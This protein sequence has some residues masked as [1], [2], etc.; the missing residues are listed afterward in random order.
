[1]TL[2]ADLS[3]LPRTARRFWVHE[4]LHARQPFAPD[5]AAEYRDFSGYEEGLVEG[6]ARSLLRDQLGIREIAGTFEHP[7]AAYRGLAL[8]LRVDLEQLWRRLWQT[9]PGAVRAAFPD[10]VADLYQSETG[11]QLLPPQVARCAE[12]PTRCFGRGRALLSPMG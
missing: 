11:A 8:V 2:R 10:I 1:M 12:L 3:R 5:H 9:P 6:L 7:V 4:S